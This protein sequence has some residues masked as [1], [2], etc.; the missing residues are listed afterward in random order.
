[1]AGWGTPGVPESWQ[2]LVNAH[3]DL[4]NTDRLSQLRDF[5]SGP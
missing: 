4:I 5:L 2:E 1:M 3:V